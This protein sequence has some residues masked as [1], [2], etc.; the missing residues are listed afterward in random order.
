MPQRRCKKKR[1]ATTPSFRIKI[2]LITQ[3][4]F[5]MQNGREK[6]CPSGSIS[7]IREEP[8]VECI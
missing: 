1:E 3:D 5:L 4:I 6:I 8:H 7:F 2:I